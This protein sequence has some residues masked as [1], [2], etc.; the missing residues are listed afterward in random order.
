MVDVK[1]FL[2]NWQ[3]N[4]DESHEI[5]CPYCGY[6]FEGEDLYEHVSM[7]GEDTE[8]RAYCSDCG[9]YF[10]CVECVDRTWEVSK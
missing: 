3:T 2:E 1:T 7:W 5:K 6:L 8:D 9:K 4:Y 10:R